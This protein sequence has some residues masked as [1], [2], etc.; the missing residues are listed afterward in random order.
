M[1]NT[2]IYRHTCAHPLKDYIHGLVPFFT[3]QQRVQRIQINR[4]E[5]SSNT[6]EVLVLHMPLHHR[7]LLFH[8]HSKKNS[9]NVQCFI[10]YE[11]D[12]TNRIIV[13]I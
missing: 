3:I 2:C 13:K 1:C 8:D 5:V 9:N 7:A 10:F 11:D 4:H 6:F 12:T